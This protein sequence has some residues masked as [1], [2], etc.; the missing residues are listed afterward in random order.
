[1]NRKYTVK[2]IFDVVNKLRDNFKDVSITS[3]LIV[4]FINE[5]DEEFNDTIN[6]VKKLNLNEIHV[7]KFS[8]RK[9]TK[10][11]NLDTTVTPI[12]ANLRSEKLIMLG[13]EIRKN[14]LNRYIGKKVEILVEE[15]KDGYLYGYTTNYIMVKVKG[16]KTLC[17]KIQEVELLTVEKDLTFLGKIV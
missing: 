4:G 9:F 1:M 7:F 15:Y 8:K 12:Q 6:N 3:D 13:K 17:Q 16:E 10:S 2:H 5:T 14:F 11:Y